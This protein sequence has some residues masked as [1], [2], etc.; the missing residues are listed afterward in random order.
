VA[1]DV[2]V[3][4]TS[5]KFVATLKGAPTSQPFGTPYHQDILN[6]TIQPLDYDSGGVATS[7]PYEVLDASGY[8]I[9]LLV[10]KASDGST[11]A[12]PFTSWTP[13][14]TALTGSA[15]LNTA[16]MATAVSGLSAGGELST[17][18][19]LRIT[20]GSSRQVTVETAVTIKKSAITSGTPSE[21]PITSYLTR[22][23]C[24]ALFVRYAGNPDGATITLTSPDGTEEVVLGANDDG[25]A[26]ANQEN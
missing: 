4:L 3:D 6:L 21:L 2:F 20:N 5:K 7:T 18:F 22:E 8:S 11:L 10:T 9:S 23:E 1:Q 16:A 13:S 24:L 19:W 12:G 25:S 15:D 17:I 14:G 26:A